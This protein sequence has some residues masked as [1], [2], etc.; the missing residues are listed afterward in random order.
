MLFVLF[1]SITFGSEVKI[2]MY[3]HIVEGAPENSATISFEKLKRDIE[4]IDNSKY[5][6]VGLEDL[7][8]PEK[9]PD[10]PLVI[11]LDDGYRSNYKYL[12]PLIKD[13][14][15]PVSIALI[16]GFLDNKDFKQKEKLTLT[17]IKE[18]S[19]SGLVNFQNHTYNLHY[20]EGE[21]Y[22]G[23]LVGKGVMKNN[24]ESKRNYIKRLSLDIVRNHFRI[25]EITGEYPIFFV[26]PYGLYN[27]E[28]DSILKVLNYAGTLS[29][30]QGDNIVNNAK[31]LYRLKRYNVSEDVC[32]SDILGA[33][34]IDDE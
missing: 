15:M 1:S 31:N 16:G 12:F 6:V 17:E 10:H 4:Y 23:N 3:H 27:S 22:N 9:L 8:E 33:V 11:T 26:Y 19:E 30:N 34:G 21:D 5:E 13:K 24:A 7:L 14:N 20:P 18:M 2:L 25:K 28:V 29:T 32:L